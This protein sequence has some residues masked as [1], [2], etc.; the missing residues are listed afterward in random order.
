MIRSGSDCVQTVDRETRAQG[1]GET[2]G[3]GGKLFSRTSIVD[4]QIGMGDYPV[5]ATGS[6]V[7]HDCPQERS[8][9]AG[10]T[11]RDIQGRAE[12][13]GGIISKLVL[14]PDDWLNSKDRADRGRAGLGREGELLDGANDLAQ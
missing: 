8:G 10:E 2:A 11:N 13:S 14:R 3:R 7:S 5:A 9:P 12:P 6:N 4:S 1:G